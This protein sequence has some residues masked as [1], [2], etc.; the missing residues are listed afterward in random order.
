[1]SPTG[2]QAGFTLI[3]LLVAL[4]VGML[5]TAAILRVVLAATSGFSLQQSLGRTQEDARFALRTIAAEIRAAGFTPSP[6]PDGLQCPALTDETA[7]AISANSDR[8]VLRRWSD[9]NCYGSANPVL[10][11]GGRPRWFLLENSFYASAAGQLVRRC[12]YGP[13]SANLVNQINGLGLVEGTEAFQALYAEDTDADGQADHWVPAGAWQ[14]ESQVRAVRFAV[15]VSGM[16]P[17]GATT[18]A[19]WQVLDRT[20]PVTADHRLRQVFETTAG[21]RGRAR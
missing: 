9:H 2:R 4:A 15:L 18:H 6:W 17:V 20:V 19:A 3:D 11:G 8:L 13:D 5:L 16:E 21:I 12:R 1:M 10:N 7:D 14:A